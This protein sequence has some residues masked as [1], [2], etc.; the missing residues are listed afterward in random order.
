MVNVLEQFQKVAPYILNSVKARVTA[1]ESDEAVLVIIQEEILHYFDAFRNMSEQY[2]AFNDEQRHQFASVMYELVAP[3][4]QGIKAPVNPVYES[5]VKVT[6]KTGALE[7]ITH[8]QHHD[9]V[10]SYDIYQ[11]ND[12]MQLAVNA[13]GTAVF[14]RPFKSANWLKAG[15]EANL[16]YYWLVNKGIKIRDGANKKAVFIDGVLSIESEEV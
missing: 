8:H 16:E 7:F 2:L 6:G 14:T 11:R 1:N 5:F 9:D 4:S 3:L 15:F 12:G 13:A 10:D